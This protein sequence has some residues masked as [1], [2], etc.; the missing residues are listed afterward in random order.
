[1]NSIAHWRFHTFSDTLRLKSQ[2]LVLKGAF[3]S[4]LAMGCW[5]FEVHTFQSSGDSF[6]LVYLTN[7]KLPAYCKHDSDS[8]DRKCI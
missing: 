4:F 5:A 3:G 8:L 2:F 1:L 7:H 6:K